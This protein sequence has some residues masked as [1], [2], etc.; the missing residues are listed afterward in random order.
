VKAECNKWKA[1]QEKKGPTSAVAKKAA[2]EPE[3]WYFKARDAPYIIATGT[4]GYQQEVEARIPENPSQECWSSVAM[5]VELDDD[6]ELK[7][8]EWW[9]HE[10]WS[11]G[12]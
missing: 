2:P 6:P 1:L 7:I 11:F 12:V 3:C 8:P 9:R 4:D 10:A 5:E